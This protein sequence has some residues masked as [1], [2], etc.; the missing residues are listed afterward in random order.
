MIYLRLLILLTITHTAEAQIA[1]STLNQDPVFT[2]ILKRRLTYPRQA[3]WSSRYGRIFAGFDVDKK[4]RIQ[5]IS[6]LNHSVEGDYAGFEPTVIAAIK[7]LPSLSLQ[8][9]G[10]YILPISFILADYRHKDKPFIPT[11]TLYI[12]GL[13]GRIILNEIKVFGSNVNSR[14][15][16]KAAA[17]N[18]SY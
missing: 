1:N 12:Q 15:R 9:T 2:T 8:F 13:R 7:K 17:K 4:G 5:D 6:I 18:E 14:E 3:Q 11:D 16:I 10:S